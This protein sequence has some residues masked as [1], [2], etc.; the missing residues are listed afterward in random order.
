VYTLLIC[1]PPILKPEHHL[2]IA[3]D[4]EWRDECY[5]FLVVNGDA[6][7]MIARINIQK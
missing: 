1:S 4:P 2:S 7:L 6:D 3:K 5:F